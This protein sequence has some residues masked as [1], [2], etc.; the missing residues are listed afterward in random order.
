[1]LNRLVSKIT[2]EDSTSTL[3]KLAYQSLLQGCQPLLQQYQQVLQFHL[4]VAIATERTM[5]KLL[6]V[7][8]G[9]FTELTL[10]VG[11]YNI[12]KFIQLVESQSNPYH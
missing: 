5:G 6:S 3:T 8:L 12:T 2:T 1:M 9:V 11:T 4:V 7:L 10:K